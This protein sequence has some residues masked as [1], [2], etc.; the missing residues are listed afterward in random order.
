MLE[1]PDFVNV[2]VRRHLNPFHDWLRTTLS[3]GM[4]DAKGKFS[5]SIREPI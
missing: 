4:P 5:T 3:S 1:F 2:V